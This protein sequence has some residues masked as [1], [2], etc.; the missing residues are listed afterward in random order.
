MHIIIT[1]I[2]FIT[3]LSV[4]GGANYYLAR[5]IFQCANYFLPN[6]RFWPFFVFFMAMA[7]IMILGFVGAFMP[8]SRG[9]ARV[10]DIISS[11][12]MGIFLYLLIFVILS[13][14]VLLI[15]RLFKVVKWPL[16]PNVRM[17]SVIVVL[18]FTTVTVT[19]GLIHANNIKHA[20][21]NIELEGR[22]MNRDLNLVLITDLHLGSA[23]SEARLADI[24]D[25]IN[26][27]DP[28][29]VCI[30]GDFFNT[31]FNCIYNSEKAAETLRGISSEYGVYACFGNHDAGESLPQM[32]DFFE[33]CNITLL[34]DEYVEIDNLFTLVGRL[35]GSPIGKYDDMK[36]KSLSAVLEGADETLPIIVMDHNPAAISE[37]NGEVDLVLSGHTHHGQVFP[38]S[39]IT[40]AMYTVDY[41]LYREEGGTQIV[42]SSGI[43]TWGPPVRVGS[44]SEIVSIHFNSK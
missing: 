15:L 38:G 27:R 3:L 13:D 12:W 32:M 31:D 10:T 8:L 17:I 26:S 37:Y 29:V 21:Y 25:E 41:G 22:Q 44:D 40:G 1:A 42:V 20:S 2:V 28:D 6:M 18:L 23:R 19:Y 33:K 11:Y 36:R 14:L 24:V 43:G 16:E 35:D 7:V 9:I 5:R 4:I 39:L 30:A 34:N